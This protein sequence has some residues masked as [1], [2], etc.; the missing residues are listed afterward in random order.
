M[1]IYYK[2]K[3]RETLMVEGNK[4]KGKCKCNQKIALYLEER[5]GDGVD[6]VERQYPYWG[7]IYQNI[8]RRFVLFYFVVLT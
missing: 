5:N 3:K 7:K 6:G 8:G 2:R 1:K 4:T